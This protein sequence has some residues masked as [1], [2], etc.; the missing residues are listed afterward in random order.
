MARLCGFITSN[1]R[2]DARLGKTAVVASEGTK[3]PFRGRIQ[4]IAPPPG[5]T[6]DGVAWTVIRYLLACL[7]RITGLL[8]PS[9][10]PM[11]TMP[12]SSHTLKYH[13]YHPHIG[14]HRSSA[15]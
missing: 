8:K 13:D 15:R 10:Q 7:T 2:S 9:S 12:G 14:S 3:L 5:K 6:D 1:T 4:V 11:L